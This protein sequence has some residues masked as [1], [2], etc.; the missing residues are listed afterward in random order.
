MSAVD[1]AWG[2]GGCGPPPAFM[3]IFVVVFF[4]LLYL[5]SGVVGRP[6]RPAAAKAEKKETKT[7]RTLRLQQCWVTSCS[8]THQE[9][10]QACRLVMAGVAAHGGGCLLAGAAG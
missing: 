3:L 1:G 8:D 10:G 6:R 2:G 7:L 9:P 4:L 5:M